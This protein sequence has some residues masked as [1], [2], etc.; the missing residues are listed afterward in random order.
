M[1]RGDA[2]ERLA[3][4]TVRVARVECAEMQGRRDASRAEALTMT[5]VAVENEVAA[6]RLVGARRDD[7]E[8]RAMLIYMELENAR[9]IRDLRE[10]LENRL[11]NSSLGSTPRPRV[12]RCS[13]NVYRARCVADDSP[14][15]DDALENGRDTVS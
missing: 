7:D 8:R 1:E 11:E 6:M 4:D 5:D 10:N 3:S 9:E 15:R 14:T 12:S 13:P 2:H